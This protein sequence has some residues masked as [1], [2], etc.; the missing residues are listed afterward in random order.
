MPSTQPL[1]LNC[2]RNLFFLS[3]F[4]LR[5]LIWFITVFNGAQNEGYNN[6]RS[7]TCYR[8]SVFLNLVLGTRMRYSGPG[9]S[10]KFTLH[11][12]TTVEQKSSSVSHR[13]GI[14]LITYTAK[15]N[16]AFRRYL[17]QLNLLFN[18]KFYHL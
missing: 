10:E 4:L 16:V 14:L 5:L 3:F 17:N 9:A 11:A 8:L 12:N 6:I 7:S 13:K 2:E 18:S 1:Y 15:G